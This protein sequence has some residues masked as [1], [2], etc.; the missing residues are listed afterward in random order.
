MKYFILLSFAAISFN[1]VLLVT[2]NASHIL[3]E[4]RNSFHNSPG[5]LGDK[6]CKTATITPDASEMFLHLVRSVV[7]DEPIPTSLTG[8]APQYIRKL[9][10]SCFLKLWSPFLDF[11]WLWFWGWRKEKLSNKLNH[12]YSK[13]QSPLK[14][15]ACANTKSWNVAPLAFNH[16]VLFFSIQTTTTL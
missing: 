11:D 4:S 9:F 5:W 10:S 13:M 16:V 1:F 8:A 6:V 3:S 7:A 14:Q 2:F 15:K 12:Q